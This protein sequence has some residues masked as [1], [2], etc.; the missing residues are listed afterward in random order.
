MRKTISALLILAAIGMG[1]TAQDGGIKRY[2]ATAEDS[3]KCIKAISN[4][5]VNIKN[6]EYNIAYPYWKEVFTN[7]PLASVNT[8][9]HGATMLKDLIAKE[10]DTQKKSDYIN[11]LMA[12]YDQQLKHLD[13]LQKFTKSK[14]SEGYIL[15]KKAVDYIKFFPDASVDTIYDML[16]K[17]VSIEQGN[18][19]YYITQYFMKYSA[20]KYKKDPAGHGEQIIEDYLNASVYIVDVLD[21]YN[22]N[23]VK[24]EQKYQELGNERDSINAAKTGKQID[25]ARKVRGNIDAFFINSGAA[26]CDDLNKIYSESLEAHKD[27]IQYLNK[28]ISVMSM[29]KCTEL[30]AYLTASEYALAIAPTSKAAMGCGRRYYKRGMEAKANNSEEAKELFAKAFELFDQAIE[31]ETSTVTKADL[32]YQ[33]GVYRF[34]QHQYS[35]A[36]SYAQKAISFNG[37]FGSPYILIAQ[38]YASAPN[39]SDDNVKNAC[40]YFAAIDKLQR[41]K[42]VDPT[43]Q[44]EANKLIASYSNHTPAKEDLFVRGLSNG[45]RITIGGWINETTTIR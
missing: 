12:V 19:E 18:S 11:E 21:K 38:C 35:N 17:S 42:A 1:A 14:L 27:D 40:T 26:S 4:Y 10:T 36:R 2:G 45:A 15:G 7:Y 34:A 16:A 20:E 13:D 5:T 39:W 6:K 41:A 8:Y 37:K 28:V 22:D 3:I 25:A 24:Y 9:T 31:L 32:C 43:I 29:L 44:K 30:D 33:A 23:I